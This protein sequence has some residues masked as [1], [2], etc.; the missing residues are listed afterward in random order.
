V[1]EQAD[2][3]EKSDL[4]DVAKDESEDEKPEE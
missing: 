3:V 4:E 2:E 1:E